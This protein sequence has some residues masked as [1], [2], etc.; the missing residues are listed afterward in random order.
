MET[1]VLGKTGLEV[2][3]L[4]LGAAQLGDPGIAESHVEEVLNS[5]LDQG[6]N[7]I[8]TAAMYQMSEIRIGRFLSHR[9]DEFAIATKCGDY[10]EGTGRDRQLREDYSPKGIIRI[11]ERSRQRLKTDVI[12]LV[13]FHGLPPTDGVDAAFEALL[14]LKDSGHAKYVGVSQDGPAAAAFAGKPTDGRDAAQV[15]RQWPLDTWQF[16]YNFL[17]AEAGEE[18][19]PALADQN[20]G[21]IVKRPLSNVVWDLTEEPEGDFFARPWRRAQQLPLESL[22]GDLPMIEFAMRFVLSNPDVNTL[23]V[24]T[25]NQQHISENIRLAAKG[26]LPA[27]VLDNAMRIVGR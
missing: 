5:A 4:A 16:T 13:Q 6:I 20:I 8:D 1:A 11:V 10:C 22:A 24:G 27:D 15:A 2:S 7:F 9:K 17:S 3:K 23:L 21:T 12:D 25:V 19:I 18:L 14:S 26:P